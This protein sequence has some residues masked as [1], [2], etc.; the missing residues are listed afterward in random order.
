[1]NSVSLR[2]TSTTA[3]Q[4][5]HMYMHVYASAYSL[6]IYIYT[7]TYVGIEWEVSELS[8]GTE[9]LDWDQSSHVWD[10]D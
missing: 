4:K 7:C 10:L 8:P 9:F 5:T 2:L 6:C 3:L 1:M